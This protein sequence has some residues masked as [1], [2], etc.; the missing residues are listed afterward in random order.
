MCSGGCGGYGLILVG[1]FIFLSFLSADSFSLAS[2]SLN[3][4]PVSTFFTDGTLTDDIC[5]CSVKSLVN[6]SVLCITT[7]S[8]FLAAWKVKTVYC[9]CWRLIS[10]LSDSWRSSSHLSCA[11]MLCKSLLRSLSSLH[12]S[13]SLV[14]IAFIPLLWW[15]FIRFRARNCSCKRF[16]RFLT[17]SLI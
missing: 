10:P 5:V 13:Y 8:C 7:L 9:S 2:S 1:R 14:L 3:N 4:L 16:S 12:V 6:P 11:G 17:R 15:C